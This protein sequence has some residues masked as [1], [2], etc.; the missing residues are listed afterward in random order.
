MQEQMWL[1]QE[2]FERS[3]WSRVLSRQSVILLAPA[4]SPGWTLAALVVSGR[5][6]V[7]MFLRQGVSEVRLLGLGDAFIDGW[8]RDLG[9][10]ALVV[11]GSPSK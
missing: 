9:L 6:E 2:F 5:C 7:L 8:G 1:G 11:R 10:I 4:R 3:R